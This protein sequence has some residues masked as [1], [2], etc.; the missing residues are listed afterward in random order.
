MRLLYSPVHR[1]CVER[2]DETE[3]KAWSSKPLAFFWLLR[4][5]RTVV[6]AMIGGAV[7]DIISGIPEY[8]QE[9]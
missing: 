5:D 8:K 9:V 4:P 2:K 7:K 1:H 6:V 3:R